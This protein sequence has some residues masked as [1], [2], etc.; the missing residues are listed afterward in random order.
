MFNL[1]NVFVA[2]LREREYMY[3][4][5]HIHKEIFQKKDQV[6]KKIQ[7]FRFRKSD[8]DS[9]LLAI[10]IKGE[11]SMRVLPS[12]LHTVLT[13]HARSVGLPRLLEVAARVSAGGRLKQMVEVARKDI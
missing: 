5:I 12:T 1:L 8:Q 13:L 10:S 3:R 2:L 9:W 7:F 11:V 4:R 6:S